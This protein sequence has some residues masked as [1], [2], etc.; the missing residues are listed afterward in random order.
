MGHI[1]EREAELL[2]LAERRV[3]LLVSIMKGAR[4]QIEDG[5]ANQKQ[6][7]KVC[8]SELPIGFASA[9]FEELQLWYLTEPSE[10]GVIELYSV[11]DEDD[12]ILHII[13]NLGRRLVLES[14][15]STYC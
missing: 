7:P 8:Y 4:Q 9:V 13:A 14:S 3:K 2:E 11:N 10:H 5:F 1:E 15:P 6:H 12:G